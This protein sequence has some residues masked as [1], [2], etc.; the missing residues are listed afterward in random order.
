MQ[1]VDPITVWSV[2]GD[3]LS[4]DPRYTGILTDI[5]PHSSHIVHT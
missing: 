1:T 2:L 3:S 5:V 4:G